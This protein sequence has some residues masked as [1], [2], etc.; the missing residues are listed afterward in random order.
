MVIL[1]LVLMALTGSLT[2][3]CR[4]VQKRRQMS[5]ARRATVQLH[6]V[7]L[8]SNKALTCFE[9]PTHK[10]YLHHSNVLEVVHGES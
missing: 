10:I 6:L 4:R 3:L 2:C 8:Q 1:P 7:Q 5:S 9:F